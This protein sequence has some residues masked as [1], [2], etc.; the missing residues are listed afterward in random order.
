MI[1]VCITT[2]N[3]EAF[4]AEA[5]ESV[6]AQECDEPLRV[7]IGDDASTDGTQRVCEQFAEQEE[8]IVYVRRGQNMGLAANTIDLYR[9]IMADGCEYIAML[10]GDDYWTDKHKLQ[11]QKD[12]LREHPEVG[13]VH[14]AVQGQSAE[15]IPEGDLSSRYGLQGARQSNCTALFRTELLREK[16]LSALEAQGFP[17]LDYPLYGL[18]AQRTRFA[19]LPVPTAVW[20]EHISVSQPASVGAQIQ[21]K[22]E[23]IRMWQW[24]EK[25]YPGKFH[26]YH[27]K[28]IL[29]FI[30]QI[31]YILFAQIKKKQYLCSRFRNL[32]ACGL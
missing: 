15:T 24:L 26:F 1:A 19:F 7:Y 10:D 2:Y 28:A 8:R 30:W 22:K 9:R 16:E 20:R 32:S 18:F 4:I 17:V 31:F 23:R 25:L 5:I 13:F 6:L 21:Y 11:I 3:H 12:Y 14:T 27:T 29:W